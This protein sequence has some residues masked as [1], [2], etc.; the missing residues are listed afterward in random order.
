MRL[1]EKRRR[2]KAVNVAYRKAGKPSPNDG[3]S[4]GWLKFVELVPMRAESV[5]T[6]RVN[7]LRAPWEK[8]P[9]ASYQLSNLGGNISRLRKRVKDVQA[10]ETRSEQAEAAGGVVVEGNDYVCVTFAEKPERQILTDLKA[11]G[12][13]WGG[14]SWG[15]YRDKLPECVTEML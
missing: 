3:L 6:L 13:R 10:R 7:W 5:E 12:F 1:E 9:V 14:G 15:G 8:Q 4:E 2:L 11:A